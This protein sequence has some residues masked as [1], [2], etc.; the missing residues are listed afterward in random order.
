MG[1]ATLLP[2]SASG[3][4]ATCDLGTVSLLGEVA[5]PVLLAVRPE[6]VS[7]APGAVDGVAA[8]V[9]DVSYFGHDATLRARVHGSD[10]VVIARVPAGGV[11][12]PGAAVC[13]RVSGEV[14]AFPR[15]D[16]G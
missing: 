7:V 8:D 10:T 2:G 11:P 6:Q 13:L 16:G 15:S 3:R 14:L 4:R 1:H 5:G 12:T 9:L